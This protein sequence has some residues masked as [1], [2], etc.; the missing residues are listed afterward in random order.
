MKR[1]LVL[2]ILSVFVL[3]GCTKKDI[4]MDQTEVTLHHGETYQIVAKSHNQINY[5]SENR[6][7]ANVNADGVV[8]AVCIGE[9]YI[10][11]NNG[12]DEKKFHVIVTPTNFCITE[13]E[14]SIG[15]N[16]SS[17]LGKFGEPDMEEDIDGLT[18]MTYVYS[19]YAMFMMFLLDENEGVV[20]YMLGGMTNLH[21]D[22][23]AFLS[24]RYLY[25]GPFSADG[26]EGDSY[27]NALTEDA[28]TL[29]IVH[30]NVDNQMS[31]AVYSTPEYMDDNDII[32]KKSVS[33]FSQL[34]RK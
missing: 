7:H 33:K 18:A 29:K 34:A 14:V 6:Y 8:T 1:N 16:K 28:A 21:N 24:E 4:T 12:N 3:V 9:T 26:L 15:E 22:L 13:P 27:I 19:D 25:E 11:L 31:L 17:I 20:V 32:F 23:K 2:L 30:A 10:K 5:L